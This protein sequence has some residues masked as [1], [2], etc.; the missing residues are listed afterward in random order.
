M[1][2]RKGSQAPRR[3]RQPL[4][5]VLCMRRR[6]QILQSDLQNLQETFRNR[7]EFFCDRRSG[8]RSE[9]EWRTSIHGPDTPLRLGVS[10]YA[11]LIFTTFVDGAAVA[12]AAHVSISFC[13]SSKKCRPE[14][15]S[16]DSFD[17]VGEGGLDHQA[18]EASLFFRPGLEGR[19][20]SVS[21]DPLVI[22]ASNCHQESH[23]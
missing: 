22:H 1:T 6:P 17:F 5:P 10:H 14:V 12:N 18:V 4:A 9:F 13:R 11:C 20:E 2:S 3:L 21:R 8:V 19:P 7:A 23:V 16:L 15:V